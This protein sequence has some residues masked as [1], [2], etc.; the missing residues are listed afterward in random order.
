MHMP[1]ESNLPRG[2][3]APGFVAVPDLIRITPT[4]RRR[5]GPSFGVREANLSGGV[6][7]EGMHAESLPAIEAAL[8]ALLD[9]PLPPMPQGESPAVRIATLYVFA[10]GAI[11]RQS[12][13]AITPQLYVRMQ[14]GSAAGAS[15]F[16]VCIPTAHSHATKIAMEWAT[17][18]FNRLA[19]GEKPD[20]T[21]ERDTV[22]EALKAFANP[23]LNT[24]NM[25]SAAYELDVPVQTLAFATVVL[26]TGSRSR[27][28][29]S[30]LTDATPA[31]AMR[32][33]NSKHATARVLR[34]GGL[35]GGDNHIVT[36]A[37]KALEAAH[38]LGFPVV[39]KPMDLQQGTGV[40]ADLRDDASVLHGWEVARAASPNVLVE[41]WAPGFTHRLTVFNGRVIRVTRRIAG[42]VVGD[43][44]ATIATLVDAQQQSEMLQRGLRRHGR[45]LLDLDSEALDLLR[46]NGQ[47]SSD[48]PKA[49]E[50]VR[51]RRRDNVNAGG[52][53]DNLTLD[54]SHPDNLQLAI[55]ATA[56]L[57]LDFAGVDLIIED[58]GVSWMETGALICEVNG[59][60]QLG[61]RS[62]PKIY[63]HVLNELLG[64]DPCIPARL[65]ICPDDAA[66]RQSAFEQM[67]REGE[68]N[69]FSSQAGL[70]IDGRL[71]TGPFAD[72]FVAARALLRRSDVHAAAC[73]M[74]I[75]EVSLMGLPLARWDRIDM[76][77]RAAMI[78]KDRALVARVTDL[79][80]PHQINAGRR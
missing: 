66:R 33:A 41:K 52:T 21:T 80:R 30:T 78:A 10:Q 62:E 19:T 18:L 67:R 76:V 26:G 7:V 40:S 9:E 58:I 38:K 20:V 34:S 60:P 54:D 51:L 77:D 70:W 72:G 45:V 49:G 17:R 13:I 73:L 12:R 29:E 1:S 24:F 48:V 79:V 57:R 32:I 69:G 68:S 15:L 3:G 64:D 44:V 31:L 4:W 5:L 2:E 37:E 23:G 42:G 8:T 74:T 35:P 47:S 22:H 50:Y 16:D 39:V 55:D 25:L 11:Q 63:H 71:A 65:A 53:N 6:K 27:W 56:L 43:G 36:S 14:H 28:M 59:Q 75:D 46:Q 61:I